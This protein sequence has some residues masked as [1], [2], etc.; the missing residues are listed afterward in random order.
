MNHHLETTASTRKR[1]KSKMHYQSSMQGL[2]KREEP[3]QI[4][5]QKTP[6]NDQTTNKQGDNNPTQ[7]KK[8]PKQGCEIIII[9]NKYNR[10]ITKPQTAAGAAE[11]DGGA[12]SAHT[13]E[14]EP[15]MTTAC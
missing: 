6:L 8:E 5:I 2:K 11:E 10:K 13:R 7:K 12:E 14:E 4:G 3:T 15:R 9:I 1:L